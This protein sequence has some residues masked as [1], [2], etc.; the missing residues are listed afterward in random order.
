MKRYKSKYTFH[1]Q[2]CKLLV[3]VHCPMTFKF[4]TCFEHFMLPFAEEPY[5]DEDVIFG[6]ILA[7]ANTFKN[8]N[9]WFNEQN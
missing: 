2:Q 3:L 7:V 9:T 6:R 5:E 8:I 1:R 4:Q